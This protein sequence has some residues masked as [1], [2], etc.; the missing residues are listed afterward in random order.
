M[1][2]VTICAFFICFFSCNNSEVCE[3]KLLI[4]EWERKEILFPKET[5]FTKLGAVTSDTLIITSNYKILVYVDSAGCTNCKLQL[6]KWKKIISELDLTTNGNV[7][8]LFFMHPK[9][10][11]EIQYLLKRDNFNHPVCIDEADSLNKLNHFPADE[12]F[13]TFLLDENNK[14]LAMGNPIHNP[15]VK[16]LYMKIILGD[17]APKKKDEIK[18]MAEMGTSFIDFGEFDWKVE[19][20]N[21]FKLKNTGAQPLVILDVTTSC[22]CISAEFPKEPVAA[23]KEAEI[24][25]V[26]KADKPEHFN[27]TVTV[28]CN[29]GNAPFTVKVTGTAK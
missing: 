3:L 5:N 24:A 29:A 12:R 19:Q 14:V 21:I 22:G 1:R 27:K 6:P 28:Y 18:T 11:K 8:V 7:Q 9:E 25:V 13:H 15:K 4:K 20:K 10:K 23:G 17:K 16:E 2:Y 26:Y